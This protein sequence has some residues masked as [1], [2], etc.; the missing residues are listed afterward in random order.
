MCIIID[1]NAAHDLKNATPDG[2]PV[3]SWLLRGR[4]GLVAGGKLTRELV[5][6]GLDG[7]LVTLAR[8]GRFHRV[9]DDDVDSTQAT[10]REQGLCRSNDLHVLAVA[11]VSG[12]R[13]IFT[14]DR[15]LHR[16]SRNRAVLEPTAVIYQT[17][18]HSHLLR[19]CR[20]R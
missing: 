19:E 12:C 18:A 16:D 14:R 15:E 1:A 10:L 5:S 3:L 11:I 7:T 6:A 13:L 4:G 17:A 9:P 2:K 20:C 8:A